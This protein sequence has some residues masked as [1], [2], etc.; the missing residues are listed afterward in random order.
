MTPRGELV[1]GKRIGRI[2]VPLPPRTC[3]FCE[4]LLVQRQRSLGAAVTDGFQRSVDATVLTVRVLWGMLVGDIS[5]RQISGPLTMAGAGTT[6]S[7]RAQCLYPV[8][9]YCQRVHRR[10]EL[11][12]V[13]MLD[14]GQ[15]LYH[16]P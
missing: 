12:P 15:L 14:G 10:A 9:G 4:G 8:F 7:N 1:A 16:L 3:F 2:D 11:L 13:P 6:R 5:L